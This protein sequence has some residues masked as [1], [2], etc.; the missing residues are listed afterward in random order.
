[1]ALVDALLIKVGLPSFVVLTETWLDQ[2]I[3]TVNLSGYHRISRLDRRGWTRSDR[4]G[5]AVF[6]RD[7][8]ERSI[9]H[10][11]NSEVDER[12]WHV[13]HADS[14][15]I[16][17]GGWYRT[18]DDEVESIKRFEEEYIKFSAECVSSII[19]GDMNC[20]NKEWLKWSSRNSPEGTALE[21]VCCS[22]G[23]SQKVKG[24]TRGPHLLDLVL[25][26][27]ESGVRTRITPGIHDNDHKGVLATV[28]LSVPVSEPV[29]RKVYD[30]AKANWSGLKRE[31]SNVDW[32]DFFKDKGA[33]AA[34]DSLTTKILATVDTY[35]PSKMITD[36]VYAHPWLDDRCKQVLQWKNDAVGTTDFEMR[37]DECT[38]VFLDTYHAYLGK[39]REKLQRL[40]SSSRG[41]WKLSDS[42][43][44]KANGQENI[45][46]L[47]RPDSS[48]ATTAAEKAEELSRAFRAKSVL[49]V[50]E[51][52]DYTPLG[53]TSA[54]QMGPFLRIRQRTVSRL[55]KGLDETSGT[56]PDFLPARIL[57]ACS[58]Q[59]TRPVT[60]LTR[61]LLRDGR[62]PQCWR[63]HWVQAIY[64]KGSKAEAKNYRGVHLTP[65][66]S[67][68]VERAVATLLVPWLGQQGAFGP[69]QYAYTKERSYK[70][71][72]AIN[73][74]HW[75][76]AMEDGQLV[77]LYCSDVSA[78]FDRVSHERLTDKLRLFGL[79]ERLHSFLASWL[80]DRLAEVVVGGRSAGQEPLRDSVFQGTV[81]GPPLWN[82]FYGDARRAVEQ[83]G[84]LETVFA[85]DF[86]CWRTF[87]RTRLPAEVKADLSLRGAQKELHLWGKANSVVFDPAKESF[88]HIHRTLDRGDD[89][90]ILGVV[91][92]TKLLMHSATR[93]VATEA[94][95]RLRKLLH[96]RHYYTTPQLMH[97]Y[98]A[99]VLSYIESSTPGVF[100]AAPSVL[101]KVDRV[102]RR[103]LRE[104]GLSEEQGL[105]EYRLAPLP[106]RR[107]IAMLGMLHKVSLGVAPPQLAELFPL[108]G[109]VPE[110]RRAA[111]LGNQR[112]LHNRQLSRPV[113][114]RPT[115]AFQRSL[116]GLTECYN[117]LPQK[118]VDCK[119]VK[120]FQRLP[121]KALKVHAT[122]DGVPEGWQLLFTTGWRRLT[123]RELDELFA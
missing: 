89:F 102:Q 13:I 63:V 118:A 76:R 8:F 35:I 40:P 24:P 53:P 73:V 77:A 85:D 11:A 54:A 45:P 42:L 14:G 61:L 25:S 107:G 114:A 115:E 66:L 84:F 49:P 56:G 94:G 113:V 122:K 96:A 81:L 50:P 71:A 57:K 16:L 12:S 91:F 28:K 112:R 88:Q 120:S 31:L 95:W 69:H 22:C 23:L 55:L 86:N 26:D 87:G 117:L 62:W 72:L 10:I 101:N 18:S 98:K 32:D 119:D 74:C 79:D 15:P 111:R 82:A 59:L 78:A 106:A 105:L 123:R 80:E 90:R 47:R 70:D 60:L 116:F 43:L 20:H 51:T 41:W 34:A 100:H 21:D 83:L 29:Q 7:G 6:A 110:N 9:V 39:T 64:K 65:Q 121:Q 36:R 99:Q 92:D 19:V 46:P 38:K 108:C 27:F 4:G 1:M 97:L 109:S 75:I 37:R 93:V 68:V 30:Y 5:V 103:L 44:T 2:E 33:D 17:L 58:V 104:L 3:A 48:W 67:K 52:N